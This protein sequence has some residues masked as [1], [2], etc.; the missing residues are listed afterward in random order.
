MKLRFEH[1]AALCLMV[2]GISLAASVPSDVIWVWSGA[3]TTSS[4][5]VKAKLGPGVGKAKLAVNP[6]LLLAIAVPN[7]FLASSFS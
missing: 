5:V 1:A 3:V 7:A 4:A 6:V 2:A